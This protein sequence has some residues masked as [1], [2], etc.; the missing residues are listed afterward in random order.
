MLRNSVLTLILATAPV[1]RSEP[2]A[3]PA[4]AEAKPPP[5][6]EGSETIVVLP[7]TEGYAGKR[8]QVLSAMLQWV[9]DER[10]RRSIRHLLHVGDVTNRNTPPEWANVRKAFDLIEGGVPYLLAA[11]NHDYDGQEGRK[12]LMN[13]FFKVEE[14]RQRSSYGG[15]FEEGKLENQFQFLGI[16]G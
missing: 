9:A 11:G 16:H 13:D 6:V 8:P 5:F 10:E 7:D 4:P 12:T 15:V 3:A 14:L 2:A 1:V